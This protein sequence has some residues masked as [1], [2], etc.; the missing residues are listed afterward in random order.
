MY[1]HY[2]VLPYSSLYSLII[3]IKS[4][5]KEKTSSDYTK[6]VLLT[7]KLFCMRL[8]RLCGGIAHSLMG[9][10]K[11][12]LFYLW[13]FLVAHTCSKVIII[14]IHMFHSIDFLPQSPNITIF[15]YIYMSIERVYMYV[16]ALAPV[17]KSVLYSDYISE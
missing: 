3:S 9:F 17:S 11:Q 8:L 16:Y 14:P 4:I 12:S 13:V 6:C 5:F 2:C 10:F 7:P 1:Q 15:K